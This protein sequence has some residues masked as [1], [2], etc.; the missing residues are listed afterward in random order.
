MEDFLD[1]MDLVLRDDAPTGIF[2]VS[3]GE[4]HTIKEVFDAVV[5]Y[6]GITLTEPVP[7]VPPGPDDVPAVVLDPVRTDAA[8]RLARQDRLRRD[9]RTHAA[10]VR[11]ARRVG[12]LQPPASA[13]GEGADAR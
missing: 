9:D 10:L 2:N 5:A 13:C 11:R 12:D 4:G 6:L 8:A 7:V 1:I 3:T